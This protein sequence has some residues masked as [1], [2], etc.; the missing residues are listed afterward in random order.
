MTTLVNR[1]GLQLPPLS[2]EARAKARDHL[3][4]AGYDLDRMPKLIWPEGA[5][6]AWQDH[7]YADWQ[8]KY[9]AD[10]LREKREKMERCLCAKREYGQ[11]ERRC[12]YV[13]VFW[14]PGFFGFAFQGWWTYLVGLG[15]EYRGGGHKGEL[16]G[17]LLRQAME[18]FPVDNPRPLLPLD[19]REWM[20]L[21]ARKYQ[22]GK[23]Q[24]KPQGKAAVWAE[25]K[26]GR[27][28]KF[29]RRAQW[30]NDNQ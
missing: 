19:H 11:I 17:D 12:L 26:N 9:V 22:R 18:M 10:V 23:P 30:P 27:V 29:T 28:Q 6:S 24:G 16:T 3:L 13:W 14:C 2:D 5:I 21:F 20:P 7:C 4:S 25:F 15:R 8:F 1:K